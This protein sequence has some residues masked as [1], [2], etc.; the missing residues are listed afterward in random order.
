MT[1]DEVRN[2]MHDYYD[3]LLSADER[4]TI[5]SYLEEFDDIAKEYELLRKLLDKAQTLPIGIKTPNSILEKVSDELLTKSLEKIE[6]DKQKKIRELTENTEKEGEKRKKL[7]KIGGITSSQVSEP[8]PIP[9]KKI[10]KKIL[11]I[12]FVILLCVAGYFAYD[13]FSTNLPW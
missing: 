7:K 8:S 13:Y 6:S 4:S 5:E 12:A 11:I 3:N 1:R 10:P 9:S 2:L